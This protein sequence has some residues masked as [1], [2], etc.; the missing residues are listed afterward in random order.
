MRCMNNSTH[1]GH[2]VGP[3]RQVVGL[4]AVE[5][6][7]GHAEVADLFNATKEMAQPCLLYLHVIS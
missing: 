7:P 4:V 1:R 2:V 6:G 5:P 3:S